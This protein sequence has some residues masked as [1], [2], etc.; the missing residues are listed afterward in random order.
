L[1]LIFNVLPL[2]L[3]L[4]SLLLITSLISLQPLE[5]QH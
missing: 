5:E 4:F 3:L 1:V 2:L